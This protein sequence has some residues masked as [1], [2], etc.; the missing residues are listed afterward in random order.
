MAT[1]TQPGNTNEVLALTK[2]QPTR[3]GWLERLF[4]IVAGVALLILGLPQ[5]LY[6]L[7][8]DQGAFAACAQTVL[9][10]GVLFR[11][12]WEVRGPLMSAGRYDTL[13]DAWMA[14]S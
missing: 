9:R 7:W 12:C 13:I 1:D 8:F 4:L 3:M 6:P 2:P 10:G 11:D 14:Y 5:L